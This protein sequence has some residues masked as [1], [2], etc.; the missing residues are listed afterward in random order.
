MKKKERVE[1]EQQIEE[2]QTGS[3][4]KQVGRGYCILHS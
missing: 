2:E 3:N 1:N 4:D